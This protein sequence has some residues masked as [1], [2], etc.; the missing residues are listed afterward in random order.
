GAY[1]GLPQDTVAFVRPEHNEVADIQAR[2][3][4]F[5]DDP[6]RYTR[7]GERGRQLLERLHAPDTYAAML[8]DVANRAQR[9][10]LR[11]LTDTVVERAADQLGAWC[12]PGATGEVFGRLAEGISLLTAA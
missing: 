12:G 7:M 11:Q 2:L 9:L 6:S 4:E 3:L 5:L 1:A 8:V 10:R